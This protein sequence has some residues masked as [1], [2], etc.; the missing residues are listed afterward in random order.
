MNILHIFDAI[1]TE[2]QAQDLKWGEQN[3]NNFEWAA[4][5]MEEVGEV[6][7]ASL[8]T[9]SHMGEHEYPDDTQVREELVQVAAV[10]VAWIQAIDRRGGIRS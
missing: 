5:L 3:H 9:A 2:R 10:V 8:K 7:E 4:V 1:R 6:C